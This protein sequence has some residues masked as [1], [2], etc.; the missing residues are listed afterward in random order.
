M[1][2]TIGMIETISVIR[3]IEATDAMLKAAE[4]EL[5]FARPVCTGKWL[6]M[7]EGDVGAVNTSIKIGAEVAGEFLQDQ[8][9]IPQIHSQVIP[10]LTATSQLGKGPALGAVETFTVCSGVKAADAAAK[11]ADIDLLEVRMAIALGGKCYLLFTGE[12][13]AV[14]S[15]VEAASN[16]ARNDGLLVSTILIP[17]PRPE[18]IDSLSGPTL[19][20]F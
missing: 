5:I 1:I 15:A 13:S 17:N 16:Q 2:K 3:G 18:L 11:M 9:V 10:A 4:V 6:V 20:I 7:I 8:L 12:V 19:Q 14:A